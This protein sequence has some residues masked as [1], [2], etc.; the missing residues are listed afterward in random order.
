MSSHR[1]DRGTVAVPMD[2]NAGTR[3]GGCTVFGAVGEP[4]HSAGAWC[5]GKFLSA[6]AQLQRQPLGQ[7][8]SLR[9]GKTPLT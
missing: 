4:G 6:D 9:P 1:Q 7:T 2:G 8:P 5:C 3:V